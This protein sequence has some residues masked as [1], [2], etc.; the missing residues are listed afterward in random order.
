MDVRVRHRTI[1]GE[2]Y[3]AITVA[4]GHF[5]FYL[6]GRVE[7]VAFVKALQSALAE[8]VGDSIEVAYRD[9]FVV[10]LRRDEAEYILKQIPLTPAEE[11]LAWA[12]TNYT[13]H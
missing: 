7:K 12:P 5:T 11:Q 2:P 4:E 9:R 6:N 1:D 13:K 3:Y 10:R 8:V